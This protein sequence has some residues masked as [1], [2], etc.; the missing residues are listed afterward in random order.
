MFPSRGRGLFLGPA[1]F[2]ALTAHLET[3]LFSQQD[4]TRECNFSPLKEM[5]MRTDQPCKTG[6]LE[7]VTVAGGIGTDSYPA[8]PVYVQA[9]EILAFNT[10]DLEHPVEA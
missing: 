7:R 1:K 9:P 10:S 6:P 8:G 3:L 4:F 2:K 5:C